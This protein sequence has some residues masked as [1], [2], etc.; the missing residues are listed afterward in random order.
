[1]LNKTISVDQKI[2]LYGLSMALAVA[3]GIGAV[4]N[5]GLLV[6]LALGI[7]G[8]LYF[9]GQLDKLDFSKVEVKRQ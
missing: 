1:M 5:I 2:F 9:G 4:I 6:T 3:S 8:T 7:A